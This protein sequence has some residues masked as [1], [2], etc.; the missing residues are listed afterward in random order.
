M[1]WQIN[2]DINNTNLIIELLPM[3]DP[4][5]SSID[6][7]IAISQREVSLISQTH[8]ICREKIP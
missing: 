4:T 3:F 1:D 7:P 5:D 8:A 6:E 2:I